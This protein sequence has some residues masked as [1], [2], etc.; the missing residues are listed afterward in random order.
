MDVTTASYRTVLHSRQPA[1]RHELQPGEERPQRKDCLYSHLQRALRQ[2][3]PIDKLVAFD[4][5]PLGFLVCENCL[6]VPLQGYAAEPCHQWAFPSHIW[7]MVLP[8]SQIGFRGTGYRPKQTYRVPSHNSKMVLSI[9]K[10]GPPNVHGRQNRL[11]DLARA[12]CET[13]PFA[14]VVGRYQ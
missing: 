10:I 4:P 6:P 14:A 7:K 9:V 2:R 3:I 11:R 8:T 1:S 13:E 5:V 12:A